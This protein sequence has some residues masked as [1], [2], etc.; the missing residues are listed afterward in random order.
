M[1][2]ASVALSCVTKVCIYFANHWPFVRFLY[3][4]SL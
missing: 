4:Y 2:S 3:D 1:Q